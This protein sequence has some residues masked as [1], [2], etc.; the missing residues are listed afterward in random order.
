MAAG[1]IRQ[2]PGDRRQLRVGTPSVAGEGI[3]GEQQYQ[4]WVYPNP[5]T[6]R[7]AEFVVNS[8]VVLYQ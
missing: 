7:A 3:A 8:G 4:I 2:A 6:G 1:I 5:V